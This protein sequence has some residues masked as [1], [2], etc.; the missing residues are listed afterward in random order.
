[1]YA[2]P[3]YAIFAGV[4]FTFPT[5]DNRQLG[6]GK[7]TMAP[8]I[9]TARVPPDIGSLIFGVFQ[10]QLSVGGDPSRQDISMSRLVLG[11]NT[12]WGERRW[13]LLDAVTQMDWEYKRKTSMALEFEGGIGYLGLGGLRLARGRAFGSACPRCFRVDYPGRYPAHV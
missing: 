6:T 3:G 10:Y 12:I 9:A 4:D 8:G 13:T 5:T 2:A 11:L 7:Y 1:M